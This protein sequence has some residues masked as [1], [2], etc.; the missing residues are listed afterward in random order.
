MSNA[1]HKKRR[2]HDRE[3]AQAKYTQTPTRETR[4]PFQPKTTDQS[5]FKTPPRASS[6]LPLYLLPCR[7][8]SMHANMHITRNVPLTALLGLPPPS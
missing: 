6:V 8:R 1:E 5:T 4:E 7:R 3:R 2:R